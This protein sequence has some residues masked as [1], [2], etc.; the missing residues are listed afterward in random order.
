MP[1]WLC[2]QRS[3]W[4]IFLLSCIKFLWRVV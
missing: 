4:Q 1:T 2:F 3:L